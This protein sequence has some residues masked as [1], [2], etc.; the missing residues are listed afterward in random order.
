[1]KPVRVL[2][3]AVAILVLG[4]FQ[5]ASADGS[6]G[7]TL[8]PGLTANATLTTSATSSTTG[9]WTMT[10]DVVNGTAN[11]VDINSFALQL[12][13]AGSGE[14][15]T[16]TSETVNGSSSLGVW[17]F[18]ADDK[19]N[20]GKAPDCNGA[21]SVKGWACGDTASGGSLSPFDIA[22]GKTLVITLSG[23]YTDTNGLSAT[24]SPPSI[25]DLMASGCTDAG[26]CKL[27]GGSNNNDKWA[28][29]AGLTPTTVTPEPV[30]LLLLGTGMSALGFV[31]RRKQA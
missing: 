31:R 29:S 16:I 10:F 25:F 18:F 8:A 7:A 22:S 1:M 20:N 15:F 4:A 17:E 14:S 21:G 9:T 19:L 28:I 5:T 23:T 11:T 26:S 13:Q 12:F 3:A 27:D 30:S 6:G 24:G 2:L